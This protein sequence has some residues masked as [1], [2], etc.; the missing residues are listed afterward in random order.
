MKDNT[1]KYY[2]FIVKPYENYTVYKL[3]NNIAYF[4]NN[5]TFKWQKS[6]YGKNSLKNPK[7]FKP[8]TEEEA[9]LELI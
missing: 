8:L 6:D 2:K 1:V 5:R 7:I 9:F 3:D 4:Y